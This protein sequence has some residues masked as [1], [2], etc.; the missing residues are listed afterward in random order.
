MVRH[1]A[2]HSHANRGNLFLSHPHSGQPVFSL[3][4][5][6]ILGQDSDQHRLKRT[7]I[8]VHVPTMACQVEDRIT[9]QLAWSMEGHIPSPS[10][11]MDRDLPRI[12]QVSLVS[13]SPQG[14]DRWMLKEKKR[15]LTFALASPL[16]QFI[17][18]AQCLR[19]L[20]QAEINAQE[21]HHES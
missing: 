18:P 20:N 4:A 12:Q 11:T 15:V 21:V 6:P 2:S 1:P 7:Q 17:L 19:I 13:S 3:R 5:E 14:K 10:N 8:R 9:H 16:E